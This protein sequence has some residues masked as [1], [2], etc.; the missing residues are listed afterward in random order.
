[1]LCCLHKSFYKKCPQN[2][3]FAKQKKQRLKSKFFKGC[4]PQILLNPFFNTLSQMMKY[5]EYK[6]LN[7]SQL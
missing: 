3:V 1:M 6:H 7:N 4:H 5:S 2:H